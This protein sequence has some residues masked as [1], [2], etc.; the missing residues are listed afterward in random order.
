MI[1]QYTVLFALAGLAVGSFL[2]VCMDRL[3][4]K[5]VLWIAGGKGGRLDIDIPAEL[6]DDDPVELFK[7]KSVYVTGKIVRNIYTGNLQIY[8]KDVSQLVPAESAAM[9][10]DVITAAEA[11]DNIGNTVTISGVIG[12]GGFKKQSLLSPPSHCD[13]CQHKLTILDNIPVFSYLFLRGRCRFCRAPLPFRVLLVELLS[14]IIF[15]VAYWRFGLSLQ[16]VL[17]VFWSCVFLVI[18]FMDFEH[19]LILNSITYPAMIVALVLLAIDSFTPGVNLF[20]D[21]LFIPVTS[22]YSGLITAGIVALP[23]FLIAFLRPNSMGWGDVKLV[24]LIGLMSGFPF[25]VSSLLI[26]IL[27][28]GITAI[29]LLVFKKKGRKDVIPYGTF[30]AMGPIIALLADPYIMNWYIGLSK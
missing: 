24:V 27:V 20:G 22:L 13:N 7:E 30:L 10:V 28:G 29:I 21:R 18:I 25:V 3:A 16:F 12:G 23:F 5:L 19:K 26:G 6:Y 4:P 17:A 2:N 8:I 15:L 11:A 9:P 14:P 1:I